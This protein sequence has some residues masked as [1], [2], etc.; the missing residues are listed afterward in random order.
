[1]DDHDARGPRGP[2]RHPEGARGAPLRHVGL[3]P[4][5]RLRGHARLPVLRPH[6]VP[7]RPGPLRA[8]RGE[9]QREGRPAGRDRGHRDPWPDRPLRRQQGGGNLPRRAHE[10]PVHVRVHRTGDEAPGRHPRPQGGPPRLRGLRLRPRRARVPAGGG[11]GAPR[12]RRPLLHRHARAR[13]HAR[14]LQRPVRRAD[15]REERPRR[16][17]RH[18]PGV[19]G[20]GEP[21]P[22]HRRVHRRQDERPRDGHRPHRPG[23]QQLLPARLLAGQHSPRRALPEDRG[24]RAPPRGDRARPPGLLRPHPTARMSRRR[25]PRAGRTPRSSMASTPPRRSTGSLSG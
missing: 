2:R 21:G 7:P 15:R 19:R 9:D 24:A 11:G 4:H 16:D 13:R 25:R 1:M 22:R 17:R 14:L 3:R 23:V 6:D 5:D 20:R 18:D 12:Q 8:L 10:E